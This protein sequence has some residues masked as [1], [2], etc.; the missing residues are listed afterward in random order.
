VQIIAILA[1]INSDKLVEELV[2]PLRQVFQ[3]FGKILLLTVL[4][5]E[6][7][8]SWHSNRAD[9][10]LNKLPKLLKEKNAKD[11]SNTSTIWKVY[12]SLSVKP[13]H[14]KNLEILITSNKPCV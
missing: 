9:T 11:F 6:L 14:Q 3:I 4:L 13:K 2:L 8:L 7:M 12:A 1:L 5:K 10:C